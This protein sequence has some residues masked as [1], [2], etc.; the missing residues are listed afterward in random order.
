MNN[1]F[2]DKFSY[3]LKENQDRVTRGYEMK[4]PLDEGVKLGGK[5]SMYK[6]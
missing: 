3:T 5:F 6:S 1:H 2:P 4:I